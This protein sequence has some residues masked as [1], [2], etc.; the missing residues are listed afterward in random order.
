[1]RRNGTRDD[2][3]VKERRFEENMSLVLELLNS[4]FPR[5]YLSEQVQEA[6]G[7]T[8]LKIKGV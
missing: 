2:S 1:M 8:G 6:A 7:K 5:E 4:R 3:K